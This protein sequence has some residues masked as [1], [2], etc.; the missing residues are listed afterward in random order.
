ML[1]K[2]KE[3]CQNKIEKGEA[4]IKDHKLVIGC[5]FSFAKIKGGNNYGWRLKRPK[6]V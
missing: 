1:E 6:R 2:Q 4:W 5:P 3:W